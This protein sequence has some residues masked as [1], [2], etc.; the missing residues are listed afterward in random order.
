MRKP[1]VVILAAGRGERFLSSGGKTH[2]LDALLGGVAVL[3]HVLRA[4]RASGLPWHVVRPAEDTRGMGDSIAK[5]VRATAQ[6]PGWLILPAD[7][8]LVQPATLGLVAAGLA[9]HRVVVPHWRG[10]RG[11]PVGFDAQCFD[12]LAGLSGDTGAASIVRDCRL[13]G[14][15]LDLEVD[16]PGIECDVDTV[17]DLAQAEAQWKALGGGVKKT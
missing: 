6:A 11:H 3:E 8:P 13:A 7:L 1:V 2:K 9:A 12:A 15:A 17:Q 14:L 16:D 10:S 5:G 4:A